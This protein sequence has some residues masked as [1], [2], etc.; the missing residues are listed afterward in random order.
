M[1]YRPVIS[2]VMPV[3][4]AGIWLLPAVNSILRQSF[5]EFELL[6]IDDQSYDG[7][8]E[9]LPDDHRIKI[10]HHGGTGIVSSLNFGLVRA[11]GKFVAR[12]DGDDISL[13]NR[14][15]LQL[16][17]AE[18]NPHLGIIGGLVEFFADNEEIQAGNLAYQ[19]W[20]NS[21]Q[22]EREIQRDIFI[23]SPLAHPSVLIRKQVFK[24][25][26][27]YRDLSW[28]EDYDLWLRA[29]L[30]GVAIAKVPEHVLLW[31]DHSDRLTHTDKRYSVKE[32]IK[33]KAWALSES[34]LKNRPAFLC[35]TGKLAVKFCDVLQFLGIPVEGFVDVSPEKIGKTRR[36]LPIYSLDQMLKVRKNALILGALGARGAGEELRELL[37]ISGLEEGEDFVLVG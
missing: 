2:V 1:P 37:K 8:I 34:L 19:H 10:F 5:E 13:P 18:E 25:I 30:A 17:F 4:N 36:N 16:Q 14:L 6:I 9:Q 11:K 22:T 12:M 26:G 28:P 21:L 20:L 3:K 33:V 31:R 29:W 27:L 32:F 23:E 7:S 24:D 35:G 15:A